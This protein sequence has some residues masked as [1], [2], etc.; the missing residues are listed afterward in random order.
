MWPSMVSGHLW[1]WASDQGSRWHLH[2]Q[3][4]VFDL[5]RALGDHE[6]DLLGEVPGELEEVHTKEGRPGWEPPVSTEDQQSLKA[7]LVAGQEALRKGH[8]IGRSLGISRGLKRS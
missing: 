8:R 7:A 2:T 5:G 4:P 3:G 6:G 1:G